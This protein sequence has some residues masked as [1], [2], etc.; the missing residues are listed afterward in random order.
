MTRLS[1]FFF[2]G[3]N[4][5]QNLILY[6]FFFLVTLYISIN[7]I[8]IFERYCDSIL[9]L[10]H[11]GYVI[12][13]FYTEQ[14]KLFNTG[15]FKFARKIRY[16]AR[17]P[18]HKCVD[19]GIIIAK[20]ISENRLLFKQE[21]AGVLYSRVINMI[22]K[23]NYLQL[24]LSNLTITVGLLGLFRIQRIKKCLWYAL[25]NRKCAL[26]ILKSIYFILDMYCLF[27]FIQ[28]FLSPTVFLSI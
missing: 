24:T 16:K 23:F 9:F 12:L 21:N 20:I 6:Y 11:W 14:W 1:I 27:K 4:K 3:L 7:T 17:R 28:I 19:I 15:N 8:L 22:M 5:L 10:Y 13:S 2:T 26:D 18:C 25:D